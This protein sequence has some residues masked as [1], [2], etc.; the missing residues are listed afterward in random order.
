MA[1]GH[2]ATFQNE[3]PHFSRDQ[4]WTTTTKYRRSLSHG[5]RPSSKD[6]RGILLSPTSAV[7]PSAKSFDER[8]SAHQAAPNKESPDTSSKAT[9]EDISN[10]K[11]RDGAQGQPEP[12]ERST[13]KTSQPA[14]PDKQYDT[15]QLSKNFHVLTWL[16][17]IQSTT[18]LTPNIHPASSLSPDNQ[19]SGVN[20]GRSFILDEMS[21]RADLKEM[22]RFLKRET[23]FEERLIYNDCPQYSRHDV[24]MLLKNEGKTIAAATQKDPKRAKNYEDKVEIFNKA[25]ALFQFFLPPQFEGRTVNKYWGAVYRLLVVS[26]SRRYVSFLGKIA[27]EMRRPLHGGF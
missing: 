12:T 11:A 16:N 6:P 25:E 10:D 14:Q 27:P 5:H 17:E 20:V 18:L 23:S 13:P 24:Y 19:T 21:L 1:E 9:A 3:Y 4:V 26:C 8:E 15:E 2:R 22:E 7:S